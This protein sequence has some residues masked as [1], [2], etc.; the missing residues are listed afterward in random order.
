MLSTWCWCARVRSFVHSARLGR[1]CTWPCSRSTHAFPLSIWERTKSTAERKKKQQTIHTIGICLHWILPAPT[2]TC[3]CTNYGIFFLWLV[4]IMWTSSQSCDTLEHQWRDQHMETKEM[5][6]QK[7]K[8]VK[9]CGAQ[10]QQQFACKRIETKQK[11]VK[12]QK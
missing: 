5:K 10:W 7:K 6:K 1:S 11:Q 9:K 3:Y 12:K 8:I 4:R 2:I